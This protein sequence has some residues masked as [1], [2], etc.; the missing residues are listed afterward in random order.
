MAFCPVCK[1][2]TN[3]KHADTPY[4]VCGNCNCW[5]QDPLPTKTYE[6]DHEK[7]EDGGFAGHL[8]SDHDRAVNKH[9]AETIFTQFMGS[10]PGKAADLGAKYPILSSYLKE[11][12]CQVVATDNIEIVPEYSQ[13]LGVPMIMSDFE[14]DPES[15][16][17]EFA[18]VEKF[19]LVTMIHVWE[20]M[21]N[22]LET[23]K[24]LRRIVADDGIVFLRLPSNDVT[25]IERD[26]TLGHYSIHPF[27]HSLTSIQ[28]MLV[29]TENLFT[30]EWT[31]GMD[32]CGQRDVVLRPITKKPTIYVGII[33]KNEERDLPK[34]LESLK[35]VVDGVVVIDTGSTDGTRKAALQVGLP[36]LT[37]RTFTGASEQDATGDWK[38]WDFS[39]ARNEFV[40][41]IDCN[42]LADYLLW[43]DSD[44]L[45]LTPASLRR[46][47]YL[48]EY[49]VFGTTI[50]SGDRWVHHRLWKTRRGINFEGAIHEY[51]TIGGHSEATLG[52]VVIHHDAAPGIGEDSNAR[53]LRILLKDH[54]T[55][56]A[57]SR[58]LFYLANTY[59]DNSSWAEAIKFYGERIA[60]GP[61]YWDEW[62]FAYLYKARCERAYGQ[63]PA[64]EATLLEGLS[65]APN[66]SELWMELSYMYLSSNRFSEATAMALMAAS[67]TQAPTALWREMSKYTDQPLR[68]LSFCAEYTGDLPKALDWAMKAKEA[69]G[70]Y[71]QEWLARIDYLESRRAL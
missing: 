64:A 50:E 59:K 8:L 43:F 56:P 57:S 70:V 3:K 22:P 63:L 55:N 2:E 35:G 16:L 9:L 36:N 31:R 32:G 11:L 47:V 25:G 53:N 65:K 67:Q 12:G 1:T 71:D 13:E 6:A 14:L 60:I 5:Y 45:L 44:D 46:A 61:H 26:L 58:T 30:I 52:D 4:W 7:T 49:T 29:Q 21:E 68:V 41:A 19:D 66:W 34:A 24:K 15:K 27:V 62:V 40:K 69:I 39:K 20:H 51:P 42:P 37:Y 33:T 23:L 48:D 10:R 28:E 54:A 18:G 38:L 17:L